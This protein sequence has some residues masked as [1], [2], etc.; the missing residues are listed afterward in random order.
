[1]NLAEYV[2]L[3]ART[4][5]QSEALLS[6]SGHWTYGEWQSAGNRFANFLEEH[7]LGEGDHLGLYLPN[8]PAFL[9]CYLGALKRGVI[10]IPIN[11]H[12]KGA[13]IGFIFEDSHPQMLIT[14]PGMLDRLPSLDGTSVETLVTTDA[15]SAGED[16]WGAI[17]EQPE[18]IPTI[19]R[20]NEDPATIMYTSGT[21]AE[22][23]G[24]IQ[25][26]GY[27]ISLGG[28]RASFFE[29]DRDDVG[30]VVSPMFHISGLGI[31]D[32]AMFL[33]GPMVLVR[34]W[35]L[36]RVLGAIERYGV[37]Y[38]HLI[39]TVLV[40]MVEEPP[41]KLESNNTSSLKVVMTGGG[42]VTPSQ[43][44]TFE[45]QVGG[46]VSEGYGRTEGGTSF[47]PI[48][49]RNLG[50]NGIPL[51]NLNE[52]MIVDPES[53]TEVEPGEVG[54]ILVRGD[55]VSVGYFDRPGLNERLIDDDGWMHTD[56]L[57]RFDEDGYLYFEGRR[58]ALIKTGGENVSPTEVENVIQEIPGV[59]ETVVF[60]L[61]D[62]RWGER[63]SAAIV[64]ADD[65][66]DPETITERCRE[67][68]A[69]FK[70]P[71][72]VV[73]LDEIPKQGSQKPDRAAI[74]K[75]FLEEAGDE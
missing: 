28:G 23:K 19:P 29:L 43:I 22:P 56:D 2:N 12:L 69:G 51:R 8:T 52:M 74:E 39:T 27:H 31:V 55:A 72:T 57:G 30:L 24:V 44:N 64:K 36:D 63:V 35:D 67:R 13:E 54:E 61:P 75:R 25:Q 3:Q 6:A 49:S 1:M 47:N 48:D 9:I 21:T 32:I 50:T 70:V 34:E 59:D 68:L 53:G 62:P 17:D 7:D 11:N 40:E 58:D 5:P 60:G 45:D 14:E 33:G 20:Q 46:F 16:L 41:S 15:A 18:V 42:T 71:R 65:T 37:T 66:L 26:H 73:F 4:A 38:A 10:P